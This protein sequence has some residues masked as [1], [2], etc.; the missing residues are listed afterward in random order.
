MFLSELPRWWFDIDKKPVYCK[1]RVTNLGDK[2][3][4]DIAIF[5]D[6]CHENEGLWVLQ[7][8][9]YSLDDFSWTYWRHWDELEVLTQNRSEGMM[10]HRYEWTVKKITQPKQ[11][12]WWSEV[13][14]S[15]ATY[16]RKKFC[17]LSQNFLDHLSTN[18]SL[19]F[20]NLEEDN[21]FLIYNS[22]LQANKVS[23]FNNLTSLAMN[24]T[25]FLPW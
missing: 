25:R 23:L 1:K 3:W 24:E 5:R 13:S 17:S 22:T 18:T 8:D 6:D 7:K 16:Y 15:R 9:E 10:N 11:S 20:N 2:V 4:L 14:C 19:F 12:R 21:I